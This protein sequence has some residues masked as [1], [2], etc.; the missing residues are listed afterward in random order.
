MR[1]VALPIAILA[2]LASACASGGAVGVGTVK[3]VVP[4]PKVVPNSVVRIDPKTLKPVQVVRV[5]DAPDLIVDA[6]GYLWVTHHILRAVLSGIDETGDRTLTRVDPATG[7][8]S[9]VGGGLAPCGISADPPD[10]VLVADCFR[11]SS[12]EPSNVTRVDAKTLKLTSWP[13]PGGHHFFRGV[14]SG[15]GWVWT[16]GVANDGRSVIRINPRT[17]AERSIPVPRPPGTFAWSAAQR[18]LWINNFGWSS[19]TRVG[20]RNRSS[21]VIR[22]VASEPVFPAMA[23]DTV[24]VGD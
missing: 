14:G 18:D 8:A 4:L 2:A 7:H 1:Q 21:E 19:L 12:G 16:D 23:G 5:G 20:P 17:R 22:I 6:G 15:G 9:D 11:L 13:V 10:A 3:D 24:W